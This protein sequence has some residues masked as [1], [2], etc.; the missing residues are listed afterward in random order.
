MSWVNSSLLRNGGFQSCL[1]SLDSD[2]AAISDGGNRKQMEFLRRKIKS[3]EKKSG[4]KNIMAVTRH[5]RDNTKTKH[6]VTHD[7][8]V[9]KCIDSTRLRV[10]TRQLNRAVDNTVHRRSGS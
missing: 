9:Q 7:N 6:A 2:W 3:F 10:K 4:E 5:E 1:I 8:V